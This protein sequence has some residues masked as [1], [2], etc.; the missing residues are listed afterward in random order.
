MKPII[1][2]YNDTKIIKNYA[3][4]NKNIAHIDSF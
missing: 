2:K 4:N 3:R 1:I